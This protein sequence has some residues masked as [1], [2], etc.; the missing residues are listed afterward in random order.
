MED[1]SHSPPPHRAPVPQ[2]ESPP[3]TAFSNH[4]SINSLATELILEIAKAGG[5]ECDSLEEKQV[6]LAQSSLVCRLW[7]K[8]ALP[9][10]WDS[11]ELRSEVERENI[12]ASNGFGKYV[13]RGL[14]MIY[15]NLFAAN[16]AERKGD[17][18]WWILEK[19]NGVQNLHL[20][21]APL[22]YFDD[23]SDGD[24]KLSDLSFLSGSY[25]SFQDLSTYVRS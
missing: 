22:W 17:S 20:M 23:L 18:A 2:E 15:Q 5:E 7:A 6:F 19:V 16:F 21:E 3:A 1:L 12:L 9:L 25:S 8:V 4:C 11:L 10:L 24:F 13:T 14:L